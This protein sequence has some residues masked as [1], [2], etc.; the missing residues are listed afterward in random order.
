MALI[1]SKN[2][3]LHKQHSYDAIINFMVIGLIAFGLLFVEQQYL[4]FF[5]PQANLILHF[6]NLRVYSLIIYFFIFI[7]LARR[8]KYQIKIGASFIFLALLYLFQFLSNI[9][10][11]P[12]SSFYALVSNS[13]FSNSIEILIFIL[14]YLYYSEKLVKILPLIL[15][16]LCFI[17]FIIMINPPSNLSQY[18]FMT[19][20]FII[21]PKTSGLSLYPGETGMLAVVTFALAF[22]QESLIFTFI[23]AMIALCVTFFTLERSPVLGLL[24]G[25]FPIIN[26]GKHFFKKRINIITICFLSVL[27]I[28]FFWFK[29]PDIFYDAPNKLFS[30]F[31]IGSAYSSQDTLLGGLKARADIFSG[32]AERISKA[33]FFGIGINWDNYLFSDSYNIGIY[34]NYFILSSITNGMIFSVLLIVIVFRAFQGFWQVRTTKW[35]IAF[36]AAYLSLFPSLLTHAFSPWSF[37]ILL[38][39]GMALYDNL[40]KSRANQHPYSIH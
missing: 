20:G 33:P 26:L 9:I 22:S 7:E 11:T 34:H 14:C 38:G 30:R 40:R 21:D 39:I 16:L 18:M 8:I 37:W 31:E 5:I 29:L 10:N 3:R 17:N 24:F 12:T 15:F 36:L 19:S 28:I 23:I 25:L 32:W 13:M 2:L 27:I 6:I 1:T 4:K 35:G